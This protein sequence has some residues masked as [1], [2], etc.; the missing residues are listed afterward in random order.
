MAQ[1]SKFTIFDYER[2]GVSLRTARIRAG[3]VRAEDF[4]Q[5]VADWT[6]VKLSKAGL[7]RIEKAVQPP[8][9]EQLM[10]FSLV[11]FHGRGV[12]SVIERSDLAHCLTPYA[13][14]LATQTGTLMTAITYD[15]G[16]FQAKEG[17]QDKF[18]YEPV[19]TYPDE[20]GMGSVDEYYL[21][22]RFGESSSF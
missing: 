13:E 6:G 7:Y 9:V 3:Y 10:A 4:C 21:E 14:Y 11:L 16:R 20:R 2:Y 22:Q 1:E 15:G 8:S 12:A 18:D 19:N 17:A 5:V